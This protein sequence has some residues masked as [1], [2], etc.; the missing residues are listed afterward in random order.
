MRYEQEP[1]R[2][3]TAPYY[4]EQERRMREERRTQNPFREEMSLGGNYARASREYGAG[5]EYPRNSR[6]RMDYYPMQPI[7]FTYDMRGG[8]YGGTYMH[9]DSG[10]HGNYE[11]GHGQT[12]NYGLSYEEAEEWV[13]S[14]KSADGTRGGKWKIDEVEKLLKDRGMKYEPIDIWVGMNALYSDLCEVVKRYS[15]KEPEVNFW[16]EAAIAYWLEDEDAV[17]D[18][19][20]AYYE[21]VVE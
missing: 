14:M 8:R 2:E 6:M 10:S 13:R 1:G 21:Y 19:L 17:E 4:R 11:H 7:G 12:M 18:K 9:G 15:F 5:R 20:T 3:R 16:L